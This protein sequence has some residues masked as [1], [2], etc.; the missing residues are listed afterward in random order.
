MRN[1]SSEIAVLPVEKIVLPPNI[2]HDVELVNGG[3][4]RI[5]LLDDRIEIV[6][7]E[8]HYFHMIP[9]VSN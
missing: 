6:A 9:F 5:K 7:I 2:S 8:Y 1:K 3:R 4:A